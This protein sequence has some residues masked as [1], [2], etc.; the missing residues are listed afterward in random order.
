MIKNSLLEDH[1]FPIPKVTTI[2]RVGKRLYL[3]FSRFDY[4]W[5]QK[6]VGILNLDS[7][8]VGYLT[9]A[10]GL[11]NNC[12]NVIKCGED[13]KG[14]WFGTHDGLDYLDITANNIFKVSNEYCKFSLHINDI[15]VE[16]DMLWLA[17]SSGLVCFD[18][19]AKSFKKYWNQSRKMGFDINY[20]RVSKCGDKY[21]LGLD[22]DSKSALQSFDPKT[23]RFSNFTI[24]PYV[25]DLAVWQ[26]YL[27]VGKSGGVEL[28]NCQSE[29]SDTP[30]IF[31]AK[32]FPNGTDVILETQLVLSLVVSMAEQ[33][34]PVLWIGTCG[35][36]LKTYVVNTGNCEDV[37]PEDEGM[38]YVYTIYPD[39][40]GIWC[41][42]GE[43]LQFVLVGQKNVNSRGKEKRVFADEY[44]DNLGISFANTIKKW[45]EEVIPAKWDKKYRLA[46]GL[47]M[48]IILIGSAAALISANSNEISVWVVILL[49]YSPIIITL[50]LAVIVPIIAGYVCG[51]S[52]KKE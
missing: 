3:G 24:R 41:A 1:V 16:P 13:G 29:I 27:F 50:L 36:G 19:T 12:V 47:V 28:I 48:L 39:G 30:E 35:S 15:W 26:N 44:Q 9:T 38:Q 20:S 21:W 4:E 8:E 17:T 33:E 5:G 42:A 14:L 31:A 40:N 11:S 6:G 18:K 10:D 37:L 43:R 51:F 2:S 32:F 23:G 25:N 52:R 34:R 49:I 7:G 22:V 46:V 45:W